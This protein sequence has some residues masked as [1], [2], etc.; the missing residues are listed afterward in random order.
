MDGFG[1][2]DAERWVSGL[3]TKHEGMTMGGTH[4]ES[5]LLH[6]F[7]STVTI[8]ACLIGG[9]LRTYSSHIPAR[10]PLEVSYLRLNVTF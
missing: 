2:A 3:L 6:I 8:R 10:I 9:L 4:R 7:L 5:M 1:A